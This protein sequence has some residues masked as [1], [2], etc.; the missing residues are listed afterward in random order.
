MDPI[1]GML[2]TTEPVS[3]ERLCERLGMTRAAVWKRMEKLRAEGY[4]IVSAGKLGY[5]LEP[6]ENSL[7]P[8]YIAK[9]LDTRWA[10]RGEIAY[11]EEM[12][13]TNT[14]AKELARAGAPAGS[15]ALCEKQTAGR[16][17]LKRTW[18]T[19]RGE[20]LMQSLVLRP[21]L[22]TEQAQLC[23]LA[24]AVAVAQA[25]EEACPPLQPGI[26]WP[27]D[28]VLG[29]KKC[30]GILSELAADMD[31][32]SFVIPGVGVNVNQ[33]AFEGGL[34]QRAT[35]LLLELRARDPHAPPVCRRRLLTAYLRHMENAMDA[36]ERE[37]LE[38]ILPL[39]L[40]RSVTLGR[41]VRVLGADGAFTGTARALDA[42]GALIVSEDG[43]G[44]RRVISGD[45][46]V[47]GL[48]GYC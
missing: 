14:R 29:G 46:S 47:R 45:V 20:A 1:I 31:G 9:E 22:P 25:I 11:E 40:A 13:S 32:L 38:G 16:G 24:A 30:V 17:R 19:P 48:M 12:D 5:R 33:L 42:T 34:A 8:G 43:G 44:D 39:Y 41:R 10:G 6:V 18:E 4:R 2:S 37:G 27:N 36:L 3:G 23:T 21:A 35:S 28:I 7:L 15:L 26:K